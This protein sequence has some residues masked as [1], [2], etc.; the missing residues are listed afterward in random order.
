MA[1]K[2][3]T[4][5][6]V[7]TV[8]QPWADLILEHGKDIENR[9]WRTPYRG[10]LYIHAAKKDDE[11]AMKRYSREIGKFPCEF[12]RGVIIGKVELVDCVHRHQSKWFEGPWGFVLKDPVIFK[13]GRIAKGKLGIWKHQLEL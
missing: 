10:T 12:R 4:D 13:R 3:L 5:V 9:V 2:K 8:K 1:G 6:R 7:L 11:K